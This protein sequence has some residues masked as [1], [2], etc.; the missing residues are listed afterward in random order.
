[1]TDE[2]RRLVGALAGIEP[3]LAVLDLDAMNANTTTLLRRAGTLPIRVASK[4]I[5]CRDALQRILSADGRFTG[6]MAFTLPEALWLHG[7]GVRDI[8]VGYPTVDRAALG[9]LAA[10]EAGDAPVLMVDSVDHLDIVD[11][12]APRRAGSV[13]VCIDIDV[14]WHRAAGRIWIGPKRSPLRDCADVVALARAIAARPGFE[15]VGLMGYEGHVAGVGDRPRGRPLRGALLRRLQPRWIDEARERRGRAVEAVRSVAPIRLVNAGG[16]GSLETSG[17]EPWVTEVTAGSG[18]YAPALFDD[19]TTFSLRP[20]AMFA[21]PVVRRPTAEVATVLGGGYLA[22]GPADR[23]RL[24]RPHLPAGLR[25]DPMEGA[26]EVQTPLLGP[27]ARALHIGDLVFFRH[28]KAGEL[29]ERFDRLH[30][31]AGDQVVDVVP[32]YRGE[33]GTF[34]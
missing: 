10:I 30:L 17:A 23:D 32:T 26:G 22:S 8:L 6:V 19:Y 29:C 9:T 14:G 11:A 25:L 4:S 24:P 33:G 28:A 21:M 13:R 18:F 16:T 12:A 31:V 5:R 2:Y 3:P 34:L 15:L 1:M 7:H 27:G 20:A